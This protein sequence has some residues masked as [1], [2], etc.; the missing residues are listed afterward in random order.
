MPYA[1]WVWAEDVLC[2]VDPN[3]V[4]PTHFMPLPADPGT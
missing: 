2:E 1:L 3:P 4:Q